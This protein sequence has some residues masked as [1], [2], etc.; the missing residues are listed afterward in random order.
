MVVELLVSFCT[1]NLLTLFILCYVTWFCSGITLT[2]LVGVLVLCFSTSEIF[3]V[4][5]ILSM[6]RHLIVSSRNGLVT[7][8]SLQVYYFQMYLALVIIGFLHG[9]V[10]LP[11]SF[12]VLVLLYR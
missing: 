7:F 8:R 12:V 6:A 2:K 9:L 1:I 11:V 5:D 4:C 10:F 3:V